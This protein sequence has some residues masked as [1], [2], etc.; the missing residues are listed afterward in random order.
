MAKGCHIFLAPISAKKE[1]DKSEG[2]QL[3]V[4]PIVRYFPEVFLEDLP[5]LPPARPVEFHIDLISGAAPVARAPYR[6]APSEKKELGIHADPAKIESIKDWASPKTSTEIHQFLG[7]AGYY[8]SEDFMVYCDASHKGLG[9]ILMQRMKANVVAD[10]LR[11]KERFEPLRVRALVMTIG[12][13][14]PKQILEAQIEA[15]KSENLKNED[16]GVMTIGLDLPKQILEAQIEALKP[17]NLKNED[18]GGMIRKDIPK[19]KLEPR[20]DMG[21]EDQDGEEESCGHHNYHHRSCKPPLALATT[22]TFYLPSYQQ[23]LCFRVDAI[24]DFKKYTLKDYY[25]WLKTYCCWCCWYKLKLL[26]NAADSR[27][28]LLEESVDADE[29]MKK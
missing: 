10:A 18:V 6:L 26:D 24:E 9:A 29:K 17:E 13:D 23:Q 15:L 16:V 20:A 8:R 27:L 4:V 12:L 21:F 22:T 1:E 19:E 3:K 5:G 11:H 7:L 28:R 14:L 25:C 2:K